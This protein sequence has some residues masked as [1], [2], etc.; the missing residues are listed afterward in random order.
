VDPSYHLYHVSLLTRVR[1]MCFGIGS[2]DTKR[3]RIAGYGI[4]QMSP[5]FGAVVV[6]VV[7]VVVVTTHKWQRIA[8]ARR[9]CSHCRLITLR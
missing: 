8:V 2:G 3:S 9:S 6:V 4:A 5:S 7:V 1:V